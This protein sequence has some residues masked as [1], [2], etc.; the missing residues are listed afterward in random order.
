MEMNFFDR[1]RS[2]VCALSMV[3]LLSVALGHTVPDS[4]VETT[5]E[6]LVEFVDQPVK[7][8]VVISENLVGPCS[9]PSIVGKYSSE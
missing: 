4:S 8:S 3:A 2:I 5:P 7:K 9:N 6:S 1:K